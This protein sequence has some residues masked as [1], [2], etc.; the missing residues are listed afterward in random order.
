MKDVLEPTRI[1]L[2]G[3]NDT[4]IAIPF[5][6]KIGEYIIRDPDE[7]N[8]FRQHYIDLMKSN[9]NQHHETPPDERKNDLLGVNSRGGVLV[10]AM[11]GSIWK[12]PKN[13]YSDIRRFQIIF[14]ARHRIG[15]SWAKI[16]KDYNIH[17]PTVRLIADGYEPGNKVREKLGLSPMLLVKALECSC[18]EYFIANHPRR[19]HCFTCRPFRT[20]RKA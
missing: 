10:D 4:P 8:W 11:D 13:G 9:K 18:G 12:E 3:M 17:A 1:M 7:W 15:D 6:F 20:R 14:T 16:G 19:V 2:D 5:P